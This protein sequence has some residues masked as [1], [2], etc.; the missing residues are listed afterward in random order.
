MIEPVIAFVAILILYAILIG[1]SHIDED[2]GVLA[3]PPLGLVGIYFLVRLV[4]WA[5]ETPIPF[6]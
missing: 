3:T 5:W 1:V 6:S 4:H 2:F